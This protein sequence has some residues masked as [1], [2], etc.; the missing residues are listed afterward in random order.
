MIYKKRRAFLGYSLLTGLTAA[1]AAAGVAKAVAGVATP[2][3]DTGSITNQVFAIRATNNLHEPPVQV[4]IGPEEVSPPLRL[5]GGFTYR[6]KVSPLERV[7]RFGK[8]YRLQLLDGEG[9]RID[10]MNV[11]SNTTATFQRFGVQVYVLS[12]RQEGEMVK[13]DT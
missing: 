10:E 3:G 8:A 7:T 9:R 2:P 5:S 6:V 11:G 12:L 13:A 4:Q 1:F